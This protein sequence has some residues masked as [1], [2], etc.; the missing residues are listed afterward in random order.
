CAESGR[1]RNGDPPAAAAP[2]RIRTAQPVPGALVGRR[3]P[4]RH[5]LG[6]SGR[7]ARLDRGSACRG[8]ETTDEG[9]GD[10]GPLR[11]ASRRSPADRRVETRRA[12]DDLV[13]DPVFRRIP[14]AP[15]ATPW[16]HLGCMARELMLREATGGDA[17]LVAAVLNEC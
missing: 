5:L 12:N 7:S 13:P 9:A 10:T 6:H 8:T 4:A 1:L 16:C 3:H 11:V 2:A 14:P 15:P 17:E